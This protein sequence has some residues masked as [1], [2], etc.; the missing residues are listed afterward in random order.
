LRIKIMILFFFLLLL[1]LYKNNLLLNIIQ[2]QLSLIY[3]INLV[4]YVIIYRIQISNDQ[5]IVQH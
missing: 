1:R 4:I 2:H 5:L 3:F